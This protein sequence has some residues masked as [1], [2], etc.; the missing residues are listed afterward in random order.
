MVCV[1][2]ALWMGE[3]EMSGRDEFVSPYLRQELRSYDEYLQE[4]GDESAAATEK[5]EADTTLTPA[6][7]RTA[8]I[9]LRSAATR[10]PHA[11]DRV[12]SET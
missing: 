1:L 8:P 3:P 11:K 5:R 9:D 4:R 7:S 6:G 12:T 10:G 2:G